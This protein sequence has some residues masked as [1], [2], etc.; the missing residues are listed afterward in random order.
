MQRTLQYDHYKV[1]GIGRDADAARIKRA[2]RTLVKHC[3]PDRDPSAGASRRFRI[4]HEAYRTLIDP[5][6]R[7][8]FDARS[9][10]YRPVTGTPRTRK[11]ERNM[12]TTRLHRERHVPRFVF[13]GLHVTGLLFGTGLVAGIVLGL[14]C[15]DW[16]WYAAPFCLP[17]IVVI[18][19]S[20]RGL[21][22]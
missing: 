8:A 10:G 7:A 1:L 18:P 6:R 17:G 20:L 14:A 16:P 21:R 13:I 4:V 11:D 15:L 22:A 12:R 19:D 3:H 5:G 9:T 2:Y